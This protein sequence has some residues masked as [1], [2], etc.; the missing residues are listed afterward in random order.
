[1]ELPEARAKAREYLE[2]AGQQAIGMD[3]AAAAADFF[4][5]A[6]EYARDD[7]DRL[8]LRLHLGEALV[9]CWRPV[10]AERHLTQALDTGRRIGDRKAEGK[11]LR[12]LGDL[13]R[14][15]GDVDE[16]RKL[17][18]QALDIAREVGDPIEEAE[19]LRS[20]GLADLFQ[21]RLDTAPVWFRQSLARFRDL[22]D[23]RG[24]GW[25][26]VN[27]AWVDLLLGR[28][29][30]AM[31]FLD[32]GVGIFGEIADSEGVGWCLGLRAWVLLFQGKLSEAEALQRQIDALIVQSMRPTPRGMGS[33]GWAIGRICLA[34][35]AQ[36]RAHLADAEELSRQALEVFEESD[37][38]WG[39]GMGRFPLGISQ[40]MRR[41]FEAARKTFTEAAEVAERSSDPMVG[42]LIT[43]GRAI[44]EYDTGNPDEAWRLGEEALSLTAG[45]GVGWI[46]EIPAKC[47]K[48]KILQDRGQPAEGR[49]LLESIKDVPY[50]M[51]EESRAVAVLAEILCDEGNPAEGI[52]AARRGIDGAGEDV[53][54][55]AWCRRALARAHH[56]AGKHADAERVLREELDLL[57]GT[58]WDDERVRAMALLAGVLDEQGRHDEAAVEVDKAR[59]LVR[60]FPP[61]ADTRALEVLLAS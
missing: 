47:L 60:R 52:T 51:Y 4:E 11:A 40:I 27:L 48:A 44:V 25:N 1:M 39:L 10:E 7:E 2:R 28:L 6:L 41:Q 61:D 9:G 20:H 49:R 56:L 16:G 12:L 59:A 58:D 43:Y 22:G 35:I 34:F 13:L 26:L 30:E 23:R 31:G 3:A 54:G 37:A 55:A 57:S 50:G 15:R 8:N 24:E 17:L 19:G 42:A 14:I 36:D 29:D 32:E 45:S 18:Q 46:S 21:G 33:F 5:R 53:I 38:V